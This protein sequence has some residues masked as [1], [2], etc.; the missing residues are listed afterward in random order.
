MADG[1]DAGTTLDDDGEASGEHEHTRMTLVEHLAELR[2]R[3]FRCIIAVAIGGVLCWAFYNQILEFLLQPYCD[4]ADGDCSLYVTDPLE[5][6]T[7]RLKVAGYGGIAL[8]MPVILWQFWRFIT[9]G[10]YKHERRMAIPFVASALVL[11][12]LGASLAYLTLPKAL[13]FLRDVGG[14]ELTEIYSPVK[15]I[16]LILYMMLAFG[17]GFEFPI[18]LIFA[19]MAG[20]VTPEQLASGRRWAIVIIFVAVAVLTPS[21]DPYSQIMLSLPMVLFYEAAILIGRLMRRRRN[22]ADA[23]A[24]A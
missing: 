4:I 5:G 24:T 6:F 15:Y 9:P 3:L 11:F 8:A 14:S 17:I 12:A 10:L 1:S 13:G 18:V 23:A 20:L 19:Q 2:T 16:T 21:G 7:V 22:K